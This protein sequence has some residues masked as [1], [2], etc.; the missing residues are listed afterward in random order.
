MMIVK[1]YVAPSKIHGVGLFAGENIEKDQII[2]VLTPSVDLVMTPEDIET[3]GE[4]FSRFM[5]VY[6]YR[7]IKSGEITISLDNARFM[8]H[9]DYPNT[10]W[11]YIFGW[12]ARDIR[13]GEEVTCDY[14]SF[15][16]DP[17]A[18]EK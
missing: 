9:Q 16:D 7:D 6:A 10:L 14:N 3:F 2:F 5:S 12:S 1:N 13:Q 18:L 4:E 11:T 15:W 17:P 8:N